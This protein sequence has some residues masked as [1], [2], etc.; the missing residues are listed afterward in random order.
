ML[1]EGRG[2]IDQTLN[3]PAMTAMH[4][5]G[6]GG[7]DAAMTYS[8]DLAK[9]ILAALDHLQQMGPIDL[10][11]ANAI[12]LHHMH[13]ALGHAAVMASQAAT[14]KMTAAM[15]MAGAVDDSRRRT[16]PRWPRTRKASGKRR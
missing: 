8:H 1:T 5:A 7:N 11:D 16:P 14:L 2:L 9:A 10:K 3:G 4:A 12:S 6:A 15:K 13:M